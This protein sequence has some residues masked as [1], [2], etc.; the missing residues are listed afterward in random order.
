MFK[1]NFVTPEDIKSVAETF[2]IVSNLTAEK[3]NEWLPVLAALG[4]AIA[5]AVATFFPTWLIE[6][7]R[8]RR[9][10]E[11][12]TN[13]LIVEI[14][15]FVELIEKR[16]YL[17]EITKAIEHLE[18][19][20]ENTKF[21]LLVDVPSH[22]SRVYQ[23]N[24]KHIGVIRRDLAQKIILFHQL[25][26]AVVQDLKPNGMF[27]DGAKIYIFLQMNEF[28][29]HAIGIGKEL[30]QDYLQNKSHNSI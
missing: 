17:S 16:G 19:Q 5:G 18:S 27:S 22:Y 20:P 30:S 24:C 14:S 15:T 23:E 9:F 3:P 21:K 28:I 25:I 10:S 6:R 7:R 1:E 2:Q 11:Q 8:D 12:I 13:C 4:G 26:D 29:Q